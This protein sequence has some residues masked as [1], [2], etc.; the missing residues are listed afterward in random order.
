MKRLLIFILGLFLLGCTGNSQFPPP[1]T[2]ASPSSSPATTSE[3][4][5]ISYAMKASDPTAVKLAAGQPQ[6]VEFMAFW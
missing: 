5:K 1:P 2:V 6:L 4:A 3:T